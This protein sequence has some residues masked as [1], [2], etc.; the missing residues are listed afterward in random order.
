MELLIPI[1]ESGQ[2]GCSLTFSE[3]KFAI[4]MIDWTRQCKM[5]LVLVLFEVSDILFLCIQGS[6]TMSVVRLTKDSGSFLMAML[7]RSGW[8][9]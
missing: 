7:I 4:L 5:F 9:I 8:R 1:Q 6:L 3:S 2:M